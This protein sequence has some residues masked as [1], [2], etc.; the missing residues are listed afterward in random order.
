MVDLNPIESLL[1]SPAFLAASRSPIATKTIKHASELLRLLPIKLGGGSLGRLGGK[2]D[3]IVARAGIALKLACLS[4]GDEFVDDASLA[5]ITSTKLKELEGMIYTFRQT[6]GAAASS[7]PSLSS[8]FSKGP[9]QKRRS[10]S[11]TPLSLSSHSSSISPQS[12]PSPPT[13]TTTI[14]PWEKKYIS[15]LTIKLSL[16]SP[17]LLKST[18]SLLLQFKAFAFDLNRHHK[19]LVNDAVKDYN[20]VRETYLCAVLYLS[21]CNELGKAADG[22]LAVKSSLLQAGKIEAKDFESVCKEVGKKLDEATAKTT[23]TAT[24]T[25]TTATKTTTKR[26]NE[27]SNRANEFN[28]F[29]SNKR[30]AINPPPPPTNNNNLTTTAKEDKKKFTREQKRLLKIQIQKLEGSAIVFEQTVKSQVYTSW[31]EGILANKK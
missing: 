13:T 4:T 2:S 26:Q 1:A 23:A 15:T 16:S 7:S 3:S 12:N 11:K 9:P 5:K 30:R 28:T 17:S 18:L 14:D 29:N 31:K 22:L 10:L 27:I 6:I 24:T 20:R 21:V 25:A 19:V 8:S